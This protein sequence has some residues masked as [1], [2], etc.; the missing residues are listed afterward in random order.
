MAV[1]AH[2]A[3]RDPQQHREDEGNQCDFEHHA[4]LRLNPTETSHG[5]ARCPCQM[6]DLHRAGESECGSTGPTAS[7][8][9][10]TSNLLIELPDPCSERRVAFGNP[11]SVP[12]APG[13]NL[14][15]G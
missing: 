1:H 15:R 11:C 14:R 12:L 2:G 8:N 9:G 6:P 4:S 10:I 7:E 13:A 5:H 3:A